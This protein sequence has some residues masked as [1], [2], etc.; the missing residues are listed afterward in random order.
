MK[1]RFAKLNQRGDTLVEVSIALAI[2]AGLLVATFTVATTA[3]RLGIGGRERTQA[4]NVAQRQAELLRSYRD[5]SMPGHGGTQGWNGFISNTV[6]KRAACGAEDANSFSMSGL[7]AS[8]GTVDTVAC[9]V[10]VTADGLGNGV[11]YRSWIT[12]VNP[13]Q[14]GKM[15]FIIHVK[16]D[17][18]S[19][20]GQT[21]STYLT[22]ADIS[23]IQQ[24][25]IGQ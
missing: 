12:V 6:G 14:L 15:S 16:W 7:D 20:E 18:Q 19:G 24:L 1:M 9:K 21:T 25:G 11:E 5:A 3:Y 17:G 22:L 8:T 13:A 10:A 2:L 4:L 23:N